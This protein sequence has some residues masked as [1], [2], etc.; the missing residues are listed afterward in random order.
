MELDTSSQLK[1][2]VKAFSILELHLKFSFH[3]QEPFTL[4]HFH[5]FTL[6]PP[7]AFTPGH[8]VFPFSPHRNSKE[9][10]L[11]QEIDQAPSIY[12]NIDKIA[13]NWWT[14]LCHV[15]TF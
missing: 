1:E 5:T 14:N 3:H 13:Y 6:S 8:Q 11:K 15:F 9:E 7:G 2:I 10:P 4:S 12:A